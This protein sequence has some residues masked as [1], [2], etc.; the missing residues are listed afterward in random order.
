[1]EHSGFGVDTMRN[2]L[3]ASRAS[4][5]PAFVR[6]PDSTRPAISGIL[7]LGADGL[8]LP[9][10]ES[11]EQARRIV[12]YARYPPEGSRGVKAYLPDD[13]VG[14]GLAATLAHANREILVIAQVETAAGV[15]HVEEIAAVDGID[16]LFIGHFDLTTSLGDP[17]AFMSPPHAAAVDRVMAAAAA[18]SKPVGSLANDL[19]DARN[20]LDRGFRMIVLGDLAVFQIAL[21]SSLEALVP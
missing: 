21:R 2:V 5:I 15:E 9:M 14:G 1:M 6:P 20:L 4:S 3:A 7:D 17:G 18:V 19:D 12:E 8:M 11:A 16:M 13:I 10:V